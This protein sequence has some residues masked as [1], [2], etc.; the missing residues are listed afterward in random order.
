LPVRVG[1]GEDVREL[2]A[3][4]ACTLTVGERVGFA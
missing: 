2:K 3:G 1:L 4:E